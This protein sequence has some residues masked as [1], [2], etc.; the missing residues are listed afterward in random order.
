[1]LLN[2]EILIGIYD[3]V[4]TNLIWVGLGSNNNWSNAQ[5]WNINVPKP[6][7][8]LQF[9]GTTRL[10]P[11]N[12]LTI[13]TPYNGITFNA[14]A[15]AFTL[16][17]NR[18]ILNSDSI[19]NNSSNTQTINNDIILGS[20]AGTVNCNT[21][22]I[23]LNGNI[24]GSGSLTKI[25]TQALSLS[26]NN[27]YTGNTFI[28]AG[29]IN[30]FNSNPFGTG[31]VYL[32]SAT[33]PTNGFINIPSTATPANTII[34]NP[35]YINGAAGTSLIANK[36]VTL[37]GL[38]VCGPIDNSASNITQTL[39][40]NDGNTITI[41]GGVSGYSNWTGAFNI[42]GTSTHGLFII[43]SPII[44]NN[45]LNTFTFNSPTP[46]T[47]TFNVSGHRFYIF[48]LIDGMAIMNTSFVIN[49]EMLRIGNDTAPINPKIPLLNLNGTDQILRNINNNSTNFA[50][51]TSANIF[52]N[53]STFSN[54]TANNVATFGYPTNTTYT[55]SISG[56]IN[57]IKTGTGTLT[58]SGSTGLNIGPR[59]TGFTAISS[60]T[61]IN[62]ALSSNPSNKVNFAQFTNTALTVNFTTPPNVGDSFILLPARTVNLYPSVSLVNASSRSG[63]YNSSTS[64]LSI[65]S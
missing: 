47:V 63:D 30:V 42:F 5:N 48:R 26:G 51:C 6:Y 27:T 32:S 28:N 17:G 50:S 33:V 24:S 7:D 62:Y 40:V 54:L 22:A 25:G 45:A 65:T 49:N 64:T 57:L 39:R 12:D 36:S 60:G 55:G 37:N 38:I 9:A 46:S 41:N 44:L 19:I 14:G 11:F 4:P 8:I 56:N 1:M 59:Y 61:L 34:N 58:L 18:F 13:D 16:S 53:S 35:I 31:S 15:G 43:N 23:N 52:N 29:T 21:A 3:F 10:T 2:K 20:N